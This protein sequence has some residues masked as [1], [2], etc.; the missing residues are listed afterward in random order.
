MK[1]YLSIENSQGIYVARA[2][3]SSNETTIDFANNNI[4]K[5]SEDSKLNLPAIEAAPIVEKPIDTTPIVAK[6]VTK[7][8]R[9]DKVL[10]VLHLRKKSTKRE[11]N[12]KADEEQP[13]NDVA[14]ASTQ[15][16]SPAKFGKNKSRTTALV[17]KFSIIKKSTNGKK[18]SIP[19]RTATSAET[20]S[21]PSVL[22]RQQ[23]IEVPISS[24]STLSLVNIDYRQ[25]NGSG[26]DLNVKF[27]HNQTIG[28]NNGGNE[29]IDIIGSDGRRSTDQLQI[30]ILGKKQ[31][32]T[33]LIKRTQPKLERMQQQQK[34]N[35]TH[36]FTTLNRTIVPPEPT[37]K[38]L[39]IPYQISS[40]KI[41]SAVQNTNRFNSNSTTK[42]I[43]QSPAIDV[44]DRTVGGENK[45]LRQF[46]VVAT[47]FDCD[48][49]E[50]PLPPQL[51]SEETKNSLLLEIIEAERRN[52]MSNTPGTSNVGTAI[53]NICNVSD[54]IAS[55]E[56]NAK[57]SSSV[58]DDL[59]P[60][61]QI[62][63]S[64]KMDI[65]SSTIELNTEPSTAQ[66]TTDLSD[67][68][69]SSPRQI[70]KFEV[71]KQVRPTI[72]SNTNLLSNYS[73]SDKDPTTI[74]MSFKQ[75]YTTN[76]AGDT[77]HTNTD[78]Y[79]RNNNTDTSI[80]CT[81][82][83]PTTSDTIANDH[84]LPKEC[85]RKISYITETYAIKTIGSSLSS[86]NCE[87][88][89]EEDTQTEDSDQFRLDSTQYSDLNTQTTFIADFLMPAYGDL[90]WNDDGVK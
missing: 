64:L 67:I 3:F 6:S 7:K 26:N 33:E 32:H 37:T 52:S 86:T 42:T 78:L 16:L 5:I 90:V 22:N 24:T 60:D 34:L 71:G 30:T 58:V 73:T 1:K 45:S 18:S 81:S 83:V 9:F 49:Q 63:G 39:S 53:S 38:A 40:G 25:E 70:L 62:T 61:N 57:A 46:S 55:N 66:E 59:Q 77:N 14:S 20:I 44:D 41:K 15:S 65:D 12:N 31:N 75:D 10:K 17:K 19:I 89:E 69:S 88:E 50:F 48:E 21:H 28:F 29:N 2:S 82:E 36:D 85:R 84:Q 51:T 13:V 87:G 43:M 8:K 72:I 79:M 23:A 54:A 76:S 4:S 27:D 68:K 56:E 11:M 74:S 35:I 80:V 47:S